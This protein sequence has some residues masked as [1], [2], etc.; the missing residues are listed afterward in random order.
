MATDKNEPNNIENNFDDEF[1]I[2][3]ED[4]TPEEDRG[5]DPM[6]EDIVKNLEDD[7]LEEFSKEKAKQ[8]KK[9]WHDERRAKEAALREREEAVSLLRRFSEENKRLKQNLHTGEKAYVGTA[10]QAYERELDVAKRDLK[11]AHD[12]GD[13]DRIAEA[14]ASLTTAVLNL[15]QVEAYQPQYTNTEETP[16]QSE[17][18]GVD[19]DSRDGWSM[20][21]VREEAQKVD[22]K[23]EAWRKRNR[24]FGENQIMTSMAYGLHAALVDEG[25]D[26]TSDEYYAR[27]DKEIRRRFPEEF[28]TTDRKPQRQATVVGS[29]KRTTGARKITLTTTQVALAKKL[30]ITPEQYAKELVKLNGDING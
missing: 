4:D 26:T 25:V 13:S 17:R 28:E 6:P 8:L 7:E 29:A 22:P 30:G 16:L 10:K 5:R 21:P 3:V 23:A 19:I 15:R 14:Q 18:K 24:W 2:E 12:S 1:D 27:I 11:E 9:V 20:T